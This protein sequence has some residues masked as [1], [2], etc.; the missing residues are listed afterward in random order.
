[1]FETAIAQ[2]ARWQKTRRPTKL[3]INA[4]ARNL[5]E[6]DFAVRIGA[7]LSKHGVAAALIQLEFTE[8]A[9]VS[10]S[11]RVLEQLAAI[12]QLGV[13]IAIDDFGTG[14]SSLSY[15]QQIPAS[16]LKIDQSFIKGLAQSEHDQKLVRA[17][18]FMAHDLGFRVVAEGIENQATFDLLAGWKCDE[19]QGYQIA[20]PQTAKAMEAWLGVV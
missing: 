20:R 8:S 15:L 18:I 6:G 17:V 16:V 9:L 7:M 10:H 11:M 13:S 2:L 19:G 4:S 12:K 1:V 3:S 5:E 14:Y